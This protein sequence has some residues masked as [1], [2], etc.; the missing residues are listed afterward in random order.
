MLRSM[1]SGVSGLKV[2]QT[3]LDVIGNNIANVNTTGFKRST[4]SFEEVFS[5]TIKSAQPSTSNGRG[6]TNPS[7]IGLGTSIGGVSTIHTSGNLQRTD[8]PNDLAIEGNGF[9]IVSDGSNTRYTRAG[10]FSVDNA[11]NLVTSGGEKVLGWNKGSRSSIDTSKP[12]KPISLSSLKMSAEST[13]SLR[14]E[15][16]L[17]S[18]IDEFIQTAVNIGE[19]GNFKVATNSEAETLGEWKLSLGGPITVGKYIKIGGVTITNTPSA[20][21][22]SVGTF[23]TTTKEQLTDIRNFLVDPSTKIPTTPTAP[24]KVFSDYYEVK[25]DDNDLVIT[26]KPGQATGAAIDFNAGTSGV[27]ITKDEEVESEVGTDGVYTV[28]ITKN[29][30]EGDTISINGEEYTAVAAGA[31]DHQFD[32]GTDTDETA[33]NLALAINA[34]FDSEFSAVVDPGDSTIKLTQNIPSGVDIERDDIILPSPIEENVINY[35]M[36]IYDS[37]GDAHTITAKFMKTGLN[38]FSYDITTTDPTID[39]IKA[40][41]GTVKF[42]NDGKLDTSATGTKTKDIKIEFKNG[43]KDISID[44][45]DIV[46]DKDKFTQ[47]S[48]DTNIS[49]GQNGYASGKLDSLS[50]DGEGK[51]ICRFTN[52][53][54]DHKA[55]IALASFINP[56]GLEKVGSNLFAGTWNSGDAEVGSAG[57]G[58]R[59]VIA[60]NSLEMSNVDLSNEFTEMIVAQR[61]FQA[62]SRIITTS[63]EILQE[64]VNL[65]R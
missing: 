17:D 11:G 41:L 33:S 7:Q 44:D 40:D 52:G 43:A 31:T 23:A 64:L 38:E 18:K 22:P 45:K 19:I 60:S 51:I 25:I 39:N 62:N 6:G 16:N 35:N 27:T 2:H 58:E 55:T 48:N 54:Q 42:T 28:D 37:L 30:V 12:L 34:L 32:I 26:E 59:G 20:T 61:G 21:D 10:N 14:F 5:Q 47:F 8:N 29:F 4:I 63:D 1:Y 56:V 24:E 50:I 3:K 65:K 15:G 57:S 49:G 13:K 53:M 9:F 46:F 36:T